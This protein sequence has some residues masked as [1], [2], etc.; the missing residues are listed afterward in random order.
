MSIPNVTH[1]YTHAH[2]LSLPPL[3]RPQGAASLLAE[4]LP[5]RLPPPTPETAAGRRALLAA[6]A[7]ECGGYLCPQLQRLISWVPGGGVAGGGM[8]IGDRSVCVRRQ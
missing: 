1:T 2:L 7:D 3:P 4:L 5:P 8:R 6:L